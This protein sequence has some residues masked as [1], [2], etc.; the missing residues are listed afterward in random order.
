MPF[1]YDWLTKHQKKNVGWIDI[2]TYDNKIEFELKVDPTYDRCKVIYERSGDDTLI[3]YEQLELMVPRQ[4]FDVFIEDLTM[5]LVNQKIILRA[6]W[7]TSYETGIYTAKLCLCL[8]EI[9]K[10]R[11]SAPVTSTFVFHHITVSQGISM[12]RYLN[13]GVHSWISFYSIPKPVCFEDLLDELRRLKEGYRFSL[14]IDVDTIG[15]DD[16]MAINELSSFSE[17]IHELV[18]KFDLPLSDEC[19]AVL[20][21]KLKSD[22]WCKQWCIKFKHPPEKKHSLAPRE[23]TSI[24][25]AVCEETVRSVLENPLLMKLI[26]ERFECFDIARLRKVSRGIRECI[27][28]VKPDP[29]IEKYIIYSDCTGQFNVLKTRAE[30]ENGEVKEIFYQAGEN[31]FYSDM[32]SEENDFDVDILSEENEFYFD[33]LSEEINLDVVIQSEKNDVDVDIQ[34]EGNDVDVDSQS[35]EN[36]SD[37]DSQNVPEQNW[38]DLFLNDFETTLRHQKSC[39]EE[40]SIVYEYCY[41]H[42]L[43]LREIGDVLRSR[44]H[45]LKTKKFSIKSS[46]QLQVVGLLETIDKDYLKIIE[47]LF[48]VEITSGDWQIKDLPMEVDKLSKTDQWKNADQLIAKRFLITTPI[49]KM[50][51]LHFANLEIMVEYL[52]AQDVFYLNT[53]LLKSTRK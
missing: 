18:I 12:I 50:N 21:D 38:S 53:N 41:F 1:A 17:V 4:F 10:S 27:D 15:K 45:P 5:V 44:E 37:V 39:M 20:S 7:V 3:T 23:Q 19:R 32:L 26:L 11:T 25:P 6:F 52:S 46:S 36:D 47:F 9:L 51:I 13:S 2:R 43:T 28:T 33:I 8:D 49:Q 24:I 22:H 40:L 42:E 35:E 31:E 29:H 30:L 16:M 48:P 14:K 34:S